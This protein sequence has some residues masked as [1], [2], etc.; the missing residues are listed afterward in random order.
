M[1]R[2]K[3]QRGTLKTSFSQHFSPF[4]IQA[5]KGYL[6]LDFANSPLKK[7]IETRGVYEHALGIIED[8]NFKLIK[9]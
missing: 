1:S 3:L 7:Q 4:D 2:S 6:P 9:I 5:Q 8:R